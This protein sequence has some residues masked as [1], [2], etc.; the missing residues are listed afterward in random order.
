MR[1]YYQRKHNKVKELISESRL[2]DYC[3]V[4]DNDAGLHFFLKIKTGLEDEVLK[5]KLE[6][7]GIRIK[8]LS[9]YE[10]T[11]D[12]VEQHLFILNYS[13]IALDKLKGAFDLI[14]ECI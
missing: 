12:T 11:K 4:I 10:L 13:N 8:F 5:R 2:K 7:R 6:E 9:D 14:F 3:E 1:L